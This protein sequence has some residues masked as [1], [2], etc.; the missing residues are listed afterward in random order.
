MKRYISLA[1]ALLLTASLLAGCGGGKPEAPS[2]EP[3]PD[4]FSDYDPNTPP[5]EPGDI[6]LPIS[7]AP[8]TFE[9]WTP[10]FAMF[11]NLD[12]SF[13]DEIA[14]ET[15]VTLNLLVPPVGTEGENFTGL[16]L[17]GD[18]PDFASSVKRYYQGDANK[19]LSDGLI[20]RLNEAIDRWMPN[21]R[22]IVERDEATFI[23][24]VNDAG[25]I[26]GIHTIADAPSGATTGLGVR[27]DW[28]DKLGMSVSD[29]ETVDGLERALESFKQYTTD[30]EG[31][32]WLGEHSVCNAYVLNGSWGYA[33]VSYSPFINKDGTA[34]YAAYE[35]L[36]GYAATLADW[37]AKG[38]INRNYITR[39]SMSA[40]EDMWAH[41][42]IGAGDFGFAD[43][44]GLASL[45]TSSE[46]A[47]DPD[48]RLAAITTPKL[49][50]T[51]DWSDIHLRQ[52]SPAV[53]TSSSISILSNCPDLKIA[54]EYWNYVVSLADKNKVETE[55]P[56]EYTANMDAWNRVGCDWVFPENAALTYDESVEV[57]SAINNCAIA[58]NEWL[59]K[60]I[61][62]EKSADSYPELIEQLENDMDV[63]RVTEAYQAAL[64]RYFA[65]ASFM[66]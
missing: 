9:Y 45:A 12:T 42:Y 21:Y 11:E 14:A 44:D 43:G 39:S 15:G 6:S 1:I 60:V 35:G 56:S 47:P 13:Y 23:D 32:L 66:K 25:D 30:G 62:G 55:L 34:V 65:R 49:S 57:S 61:V 50:A 51:D 37:Y 48:F 52:C 10:S 22:V 36:Q 58:A 24:C 46:I 59:T 33:G 38:L 5:T 54:C 3:T 16:V 4:Y 29:L 26:W 19:A 20:V 17:S 53:N 31:P 18:L 8:I 2:V 63:G 7:A 64:D 41:G 27:A 28:L 40:P